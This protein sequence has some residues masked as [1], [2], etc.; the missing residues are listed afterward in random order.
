MKKFLLALVFTLSLFVAAAYEFPR[1]G[2]VLVTAE[3]GTIVGIGKLVDGEEFELEVLVDFTGFG[4]LVFTTPDGST[5]MLDVMIGK[6]IVSVD[7]MDLE[8]VL[9][10]AGFTEINITTD[11]NLAG[12]GQRSQRLHSHCGSHARSALG[13]QR[14][15]H[16]VYQRL[17]VCQYS[18]VCQQG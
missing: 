16:P 15:H 5:Q 14:L 6:G 2:S 7:L 8:S 17:Q 10:N 9:S 18:Q 3:D 11:A 4:K 13:P 12:P 1:D